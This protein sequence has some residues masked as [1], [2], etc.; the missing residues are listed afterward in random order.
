MEQILISKK[1]ASRALSISLRKLDYLIASKEIAVR[2]IGRRVLIPRRA[3]YEFARRDH[4]TKNAGTY[5]AER[6][7]PHEGR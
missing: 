3:L 5:L 6:R 4:L 2:R 7:Q 1:N